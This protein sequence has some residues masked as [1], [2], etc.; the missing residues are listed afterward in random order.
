MPSSHSQI[1]FCLGSSSGRNF[2]PLRHRQLHAGTSCLGQPN[3]N[4]L[5]RRLSAM[6]SFANMMHLFTDKLAGLCAGRFSLLRIVTS[7][8]R[9][10][11]LLLLHVTPSI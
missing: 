8:F 7:F 6:L 4:G 11:L 2:A 9:D 3:G 10:I 5:L 1:A